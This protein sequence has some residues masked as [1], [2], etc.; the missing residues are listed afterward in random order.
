M[1]L[2]SEIRCSRERFTKTIL[3]E[4]FKGLK[5]AFKHLSNVLLIFSKNF[6]GPLAF[7]YG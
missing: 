7:M 2:K 4:I 6:E 3:F 1:N 5:K